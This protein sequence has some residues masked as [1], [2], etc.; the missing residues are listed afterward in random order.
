MA[1]K[2][3]IKENDYKALFLSRYL[4]LIII[5]A[6]VLCVFNYLSTQKETSISNM[7]ERK[8]DLKAAKDDVAHR[9]TFTQNWYH[10]IQS[11]KFLENQFLYQS[12]IIS[13]N[14]YKFLKHDSSSIGFH[15]TRK[16]CIPEPVMHYRASKAAELTHEIINLWLHIVAQVELCTRESAALDSTANQPQPPITLKP[17]NEPINDKGTIIGYKYSLNLKRSENDPRKDLPLYKYEWKSKYIADGLLSHL[18][19]TD[20]SP[21]ERAEVINE[22]VNY[23]NRQFVMWYAVT[24][25]EIHPADI[26]NKPRLPE[27]WSGQNI[28]AFGKACLIINND[29]LWGEFIK[30]FSAFTKIQV[31]YFAKSSNK[32]HDLDK[33]INDG[34]A[35]VGNYSI[36]TIVLQ[37]ILALILLVLPF[38][39]GK[40]GDMVTRQYI[41]AIEKSNLVRQS[42]ASPH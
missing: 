31:G 13:P 28:T 33:D 4:F 22:V 36:V 19:R 21:S 27:V 35:T 42:D 26:T 12:M 17:I 1:K 15:K 10:R 41:E 2:A 32:I 29:W 23:L 38:W 25:R 11:N 24:Y 34:R 30:Y 7:E 39:R 3:G 14:C 16:N 40:F 37:I 6:L 9:M 20:L 5:I 18:N 8:A